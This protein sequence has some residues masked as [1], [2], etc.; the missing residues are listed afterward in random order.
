MIAVETLRA[1]F[2]R[3]IVI[4]MG[5]ILLPSIVTSVALL[6]GHTRLVRERERDRAA[7][8]VLL[9]STE[10]LRAASAVLRG[11]GGAE[12]DARAAADAMGK[13]RSDIKILETSA[14]DAP[15]RK[16]S[17]LLE[18]Y[19][20]AQSA[21]A[22]VSPTI[23]AS[24]QPAL[25]AALRLQRDILELE[26]NGRRRDL[27][28]ER[29]LLDAT[30]LVAALATALAMIGAFLFLRPL[31]ESLKG[32]ISSLHAQARLD[33][34]HRAAAASDDEIGQMGRDMNETLLRVKEAIQAI[35]EN[36]RGLGVSSDNLSGVSQELSASASETASQAT[37]VSAAADEFSRN[38]QTVS[39]SAEEMGA[40]IKE[41]AQNA[42]QAAKVAVS[43]VKMAET[44]NVTVDKL[45]QSSAE[46][47][48]VIRVITSIAEQTNLLALNATIEAARAGEA[49]KGFAVVANEVKDL[50]KETTKATED[51]GRRI[52]AIQTDTKSAVRVIAQIGKIIN[53][54]SDIQNVIASAV[55]EQSV[56]TNEIGRNASEAARGS[57]EIAMNI[58]AVAQ[59]VQ[60]TTA[61]AAR[62]R[63]AAQE[64]AAMASGLQKLVGRFT[65]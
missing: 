34:T 16:T 20:A 23:P 65:F 25:E 62:T 11:E 21:L 22:G 52:E 28:G 9:A 44:A 64:L 13:V 59:A 18:G 55:E 56:T 45:G 41:V 63:Q 31:H 40:S 3:K 42:N 51:I 32:F 60:G 37:V 39:A 17:S 46:I 58:S 33:F 38:V 48:Q 12:R 36:A 35:A 5:G 26:E 19:S 7:G 2:P 50:A 24:A 29:L 49:G 43:A 53:Q 47:G 14:G 8:A 1:R 27:E 57:S 10:V 54:I 30:L 6:V 61:S 15:G 4:L